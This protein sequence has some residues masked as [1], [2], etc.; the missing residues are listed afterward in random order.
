MYEK[1]RSIFSVD[2]QTRF[3]NTGCAGRC[4]FSANSQ[5]RAPVFTVAKEKLEGETEKAHYIRS[6]QIAPTEYDKLNVKSLFFHAVPVIRKGRVW[7]VIVVDT[8]D[9]SFVD[10][11]KDKRRQQT[12][13]IEKAARLTTMLLED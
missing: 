10:Q 6:F 9:P 8:N 5:K 3:Y 2:K 11:S 7:G 13:T 12:K 1:T 4:W